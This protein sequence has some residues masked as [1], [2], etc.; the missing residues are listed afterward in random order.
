M[1]FLRDVRLAVALLAGGGLLFS[2]G[3]YQHGKVH[4]EAWLL[5]PLAVACGALLLRRI[6][7]VLAI[8]AGALAFVADQIIGP[9]I[10]TVLVFAE[11]LYEACLYGKEWVGRRV[12]VV[13]A[14]ATIAIACLTL[15][16]FPRGEALTLAV[17]AGVL[18]LL[19]PIT[20]LEMRRYRDRATAE[21]LRADQLARLAE[22]DR[23]QAVAAERARMARDL[24]DVVANH[25]SAIAIHATAARSVGADLAPPVDRA[26]T[27]I[28]ENSVRGLA[29]MRQMIELLRDPTEQSGPRFDDIDKLIAYAREAGLAVTVSGA[30]DPERPLPVAVDQAAYRVVQ[31][32]LTNAVKHAS[33][34]R[35]AVTI[36]HQPRGLAV[37]V[38]SR[39]G[40]PAAVPSSGVGLVGL[41]ERVTLLGGAF[42]AG[43]RDGGFRVHAELPS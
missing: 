17:N 40:M 34:G 38:A 30:V 8:V 28:R 12:L 10:A 39:G 15:A 9:S 4:P 23:Q 11:V 24:H 36:A 37:T 13:M 7:P 20:A 2:L 19:P 27:V 18:L 1:D 3:A 41:E 21:R 14:A 26:L 43:P 25:L 33:G 29:E 35:V 31:E 5:I 42:E 32:S 6:A 22:L 16:S